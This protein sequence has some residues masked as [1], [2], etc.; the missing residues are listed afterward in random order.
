MVKPMTKQEVIRALEKVSDSQGFVTATQFAKFMGI[1][2]STYA[3]KRF[4]SDL[5][6][7]DGKYYFIPDIATAIMKD[8]KL[9]AR[10]A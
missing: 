10:T 2:T 9:K 5:E 8:K 1:K 7:V 6:C 4:L 3:E